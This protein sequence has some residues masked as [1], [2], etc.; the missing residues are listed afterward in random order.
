MRCRRMAFPRGSKV[1]PLRQYL[2]DWNQGFADA[3][4]ENRSAASARAD[5]AP[6]LSASRSMLAI[7]DGWRVPSTVPSIGSGRGVNLRFFNTSGVAK[8]LRITSAE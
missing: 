5:G 8:R 3:R 6:R 7:R 1:Q 2:A 4:A